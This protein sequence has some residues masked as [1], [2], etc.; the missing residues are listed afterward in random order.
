MPPQL[1]SPPAGAD[2]ARTRQ[3][4]ARKC[5]ECCATHPASLL[6]A[7]PRRLILL[8]SQTLLMNDKNMIVENV[9]G[10]RLEKRAVHAI[11][12]PGRTRCSTAQAL[13]L[14]FRVDWHKLFRKIFV[15]GCLYA[16]KF[17][18]IPGGACLGNQRQC[19]ACE[20]QRSIGHG[21]RELSARACKSRSIFTSNA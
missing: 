18:W 13:A 15:Q 8:H 12:L 11:P 4:P 19:Q 14:P 17:L 16:V 21:A 3:Q 5:L 1:R 2:V 6:C 9:A 20:G 7:V 10:A